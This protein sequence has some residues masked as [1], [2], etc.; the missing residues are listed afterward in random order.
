MV[1]QLAQGFEKD[2]A[3]VEHA[4]AEIP[5][6]L[7]SELTKLET[8]IDKIDNQADLEKAVKAIGDFILKF[9]PWLVKVNSKVFGPELAPILEKLELAAVEQVPVV[10][11]VFKVLVEGVDIYDDIKGMRTCIKSKDYLCAGKDLLKLFSTVSGIMEADFSNMKDIIKGMEKVES[12]M[13]A[14]LDVAETISQDVPKLKDMFTKLKKPS[15]KDVIDAV[16][17][18]GDVCV[19]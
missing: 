2:V 16:A 11:T 14:G 3:K 18:L 8:F 9:Q 4:I 6:D 19:D 12:V 1:E 5:S 10:G 17:D 7:E 13:G 15:A